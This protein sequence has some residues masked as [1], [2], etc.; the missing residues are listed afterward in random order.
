MKVAV[1]VWQI[2]GNYRDE[3]ISLSKDIAQ[4]SKTENGLL[5][6]SF[7]ESKAKKNE[8]IFLEEWK[9]DKAIENHVS[10]DYFNSFIEKTK[11]MLEEDFSGKIYEVT[12]IE[13][14]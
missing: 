3:F 5:S 1:G 7:S 14:F 2:K 9:D 10:Q 12:T 11:V 4:Q 8:F 6:Y 13:K